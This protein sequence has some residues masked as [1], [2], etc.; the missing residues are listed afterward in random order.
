MRCFRSNHVHL[1]FHW[2]E[3]WDS[4]KGYFVRHDLSVLGREASKEDNPDLFV[5]QLGHQGGD[6]CL[7]PTPARA[8][9]VVAPNGIHGTRIRYCK[10]SSSPDHLEQLMSARLF[11]GTF[12]DPGT[13]FTFE[14]LHAHHVQNL[15]CS[16]SAYGFV[17]TLARLTD[18]S[19]IVNVPVCV[20]VS[21]TAAI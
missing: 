3:Y 18:N 21:F 5:I 11:P 8:M 20:F 7:H 14:L 19:V 16:L 1:P 4:F 12:R 10:C 13:V 6:T 2:A 15:E 9:T 17:N